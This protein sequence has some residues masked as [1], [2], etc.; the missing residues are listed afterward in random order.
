M[1]YYTNKL[2]SSGTFFNEIL[3]FPTHTHDFGFWV[4][5]FYFYSSF[6]S[7]DLN[8]QNL[9]MLNLIH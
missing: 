5:E 8:E 7:N 6:Y 1:K 4:K 9:I 2:P 3:F